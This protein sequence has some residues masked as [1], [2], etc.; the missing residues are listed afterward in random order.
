[1][2]KKYLEEEL[3]CTDE[4]L[5]TNEKLL[6]QYLVMKSIID[7]TMPKLLNYDVKIMQ[8]ICYDVFPEFKMPELS[9]D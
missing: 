5:F 2:D 7:G 1:M 8:D 6:D 3:G 9:Q 4:R